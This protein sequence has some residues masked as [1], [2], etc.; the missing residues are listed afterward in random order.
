MGENEE[1]GA[2]APPQRGWYP[3]PQHPEYQ[4]FWTGQA[5]NG[6]RY[7]GSRPLASTPPAPPS[8]VP[9][10][11]GA[12]PPLPPP[13]FP[14]GQPIRNRALQVRRSTRAAERA[15]RSS[16]SRLSHSSSSTSRSVSFLG[17]ASVFSSS[18]VSSTSRP[19]GRLAPDSSTTRRASPQCQSRSCSDRVSA[20]A[21]SICHHGGGSP[22]SW[23]GGTSACGPTRS[24]SRT[25]SG[26]TETGRAARSSILP[27]V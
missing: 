1:A 26:E 23:A 17:R 9:A 19:F 18:S 21:S 5:W 16:F 14:P 8:G 6:R 22:S 24:R 10:T 12:V 4:R 3:D 27:T 7:W 20:C 15:G 2:A 25:G 11:G 13:R